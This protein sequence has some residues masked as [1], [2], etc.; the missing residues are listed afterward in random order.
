LHHSTRVDE[1]LS[2]NNYDKKET[3]DLKGLSN[4]DV[5]LE[6]AFLYSNLKKIGQQGII[7]GHHHA[8][9]I[10][11]NWRYSGPEDEFKTDCFLSVGDHPGIFGI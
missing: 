4:P 11:Q 2:Q 1:N 5:T 10:G 7:F 8:S 3:L 6:T 9:I